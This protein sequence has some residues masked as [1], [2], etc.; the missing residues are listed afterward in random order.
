MPDITYFITVFPAEKLF[1]ILED[2]ALSFSADLWHC[3]AHFFSFPKANRYYF[4]V[5]FIYFFYFSYRLYTP[6]F[7]LMAALLVMRDYKISSSMP[8]SLRIF[9]CFM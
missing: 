5:L 1:R 2:D 9:Y 7:F 3:I 4:L 8:S 6:Y